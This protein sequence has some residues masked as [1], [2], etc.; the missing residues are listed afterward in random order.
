L[1]GVADNGLPELLGYIGATPKS[2]SKVILSSDE[3]DPILTVWQYGL[4]KT[5]AWNSDISGRWSA[6]YVPWDKNIKLWQNMI[7]W[8]IENY[9]DENA[10]VEAA[11]EGGRGTIT[12]TDKE[13]TEELETVATIISPDMTSREIKLFPVAPGKYSSEFDINETGAYM[14]NVNQTK[15]GEVARALSTGLPIQYSPEYK[16][17]TSSVNI[18]RLIQEAGG[19][20]IKAAEEVFQGNIKD[21]TGRIDLTPHLLILSLLLFMMDIALR[22]LNLPLQKVEEGIESLRQKLRKEK[23]KPVMKTIEVKEKKAHAPEP[24]KEAKP[25]KKEKPRQD[26]LDVDMLL[27][28]KENKYR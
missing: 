26:N 23:K 13:G 6:N 27:K 3:D 8:T 2:T 10:S 20:Y 9:D 1:S 5:A 7:N 4:G 25:V 14:V 17:T 16:I 22:R 11:A 19:K 28:K 24:P 15:N 12:F 21:T 18:D